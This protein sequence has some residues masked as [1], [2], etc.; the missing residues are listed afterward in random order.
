MRRKHLYY[1]A[2]I[3]F[4]IFL[5]QS[6]GQL[7]TSLLDNFNRE[8]NNSLGST[9]TNPT[10][11]TWNESETVSGLSIAINN[12]LMTLGSTTSGRE[13]CYVDLSSI[14]DY[15][16]QLNS[17]AGIVTWAINQ[18]TTRADLSGL[19]SSSY[20]I[21]F[22]LAAEFSD[23]TSG[24]GYGVYI[25]GTGSPDMVR[26]FRFN[27]GIVGTKTDLIT[28]GSVYGNE[29][30][31]L[32]VMYNP[33]GQGWSLFME[34]SAFAFPQ[35]D[36]RNTATQ[37]GT[38]TANS[39]Y[40]DLMLNYLGVIW[41][42]GIASESAFIDD[43]YIT[44]SEGALPV[45]LTSFT[46]Q[47]KKDIIL[48]N[49]STATEINN[50]GFGVERKAESS[51]W[52]TI[53]FV[54]GSGNC[55]SPKTYSFCDLTPRT[56]KILYRLKQIDNNGSYKFYYANEI[57]VNVDGYELKQNYPNPFNPLTH[58]SYSL[59]VK[60]NVKL[61]VYDLLGREITV[62]VNSQME[63][64][65][66]NVEFDGGKLSSGIYYYALITNGFLQAKKLVLLK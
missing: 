39:T 46:V 19:G 38:T 12:N 45:E 48:L 44:D 53:G 35:N 21:A 54:K 15:P 14:S 6:K 13:W 47:W 64:G 37:I 30:I 50:F 51:D 63:A 20:G 24:R 17:A 62:L 36:P 16:V 7:A 18:R 55:N 34:S 59:P 56:G 42:H 65:I 43:I 58:I 26:F 10:S 52:E 4:L 23:I 33:S 40:T 66:Y 28:G 22:I 5:D 25:G 3:F 31:S 60:S 27:G 41:N 57:E 9:P 29:Y 11:L 61:A 1:L 8:D 2:I 32:K 49:W